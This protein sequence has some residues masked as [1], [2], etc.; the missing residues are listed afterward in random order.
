M[1]PPTEAA[2]SKR[3]RRAS[4]I[5]ATAII[6]R[7]AGD[8]DSHRAPG[9]T[10]RTW[11][12][13][14]RS[15]PAPRG[16]SRNGRPGLSPAGTELRG[17]L[18]DEDASPSPTIA[19]RLA[20]GALRPARPEPRG[21]RAPVTSPRVTRSGTDPGHDPVDQAASRQPAV[22]NCFCHTAAGCRIPG[23][24]GVTSL[25]Q[26]GAIQIA[27]PAVHVG[28]GTGRYV[29]DRCGCWRRRPDSN[30]GWRF[31][32]PLPYHLATAPTS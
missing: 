2:G 21:E 26:Q 28:L 8:V 17:P 11:V 4:P 16:H 19:W 1:S 7:E 3:G 9:S 13:S 6:A 27:G 15:S 10:P 20:T 18:A 30:R 24:Q 22:A 29:S 14:P 25:L 32:R 31:C 23:G 12:L 5:A